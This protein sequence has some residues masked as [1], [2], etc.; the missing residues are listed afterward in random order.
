MV[1]PGSC[2]AVPL[3]NKNIAALLQ[4]GVADPHLGYMLR[5]ARARSPPPDIAPVSKR[6]P[7]PDIAPDIGHVL[8]SS[9]DDEDA[10]GSWKG[11]GDEEP[12][13]ELPDDEELGDDDEFEC[14]QHACT[15]VDLS[16]AVE[17]LVTLSDTEDLG[18]SVA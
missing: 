11:R 17:R 7:P 9:S 18:L 4:R 3:G 13:P 1:D 5:L 16:V 14:G 15:F 10:W 8:V 6:S 2:N 12:M